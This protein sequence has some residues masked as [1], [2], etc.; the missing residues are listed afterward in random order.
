MEPRLSWALATHQSMLQQETG[1][2]WALRQ[3]SCVKLQL[4]HNF[5]S[6]VHSDLC[7]LVQTQQ[8]WLS[9]RKQLVNTNVLMLRWVTYQ[10]WLG[11]KNP[12]AAGHEDCLALRVHDSTARL[13]R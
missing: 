9:L 11:C 13:S 10:E 5:L 12:A 7:H 3:I 4:H 2:Q 8:C 1:Y 6:Q